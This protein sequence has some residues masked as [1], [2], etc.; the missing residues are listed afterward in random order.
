MFQDYKAE[1]S[2]LNF[3]IIKLKF[4]FVYN[5][6][7]KNVCFIC[8]ESIAIKE[9]SNIKQHSETHHNNYNHFTGK[10]REDSCM[11]E[12]GFNKAVVIFLLER[13]KKRQTLVPTTRSQN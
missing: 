13:L 7:A 9:V 10:A 2:V 11:A 4:R 8:Q 3:P 1:F 6:P 5:Q 12:K